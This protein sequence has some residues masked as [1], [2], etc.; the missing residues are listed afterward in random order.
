MTDTSED[1]TRGLPRPLRRLQQ[2]TQVL[3]STAVVGLG[4]LSACTIENVVPIVD[5]GVEPPP[6]E[7]GGAACFHDGRYYPEGARISGGECGEFCICREGLADCR[8]AD[9]AHPPGWRRDAGLSTLVDAA[10]PAPWDAGPPWSPSDAGPPPDGGPADGGAPGGCH[11]GPS[12]TSERW[13]VFDSNRGTG[14]RAIWTVAANGC[15]SVTRLMTGPGNAKEPAVSP[16]GKTVLFAS[17]RDSNAAWAIYALDLAS[18]AVRPVASDADQPTWSPDGKLIAYRRGASTLLANPDGTGERVLTTG[19]DNFNAHKNAAFSPDGQWIAFDRNNEIKQV[20]LDGTDERYI[21][22][23]WTTTLVEPTFSLDGTQIAY[24]GSCGTGPA[25][26]HTAPRGGLVGDPC[27]PA[28]TTDGVRSE[29]PSWG[30]DGVIAYER[31]GDIALVSV[32]EGQPHLL[33]TGREDDAN[34]TWAP[35]DFAPT[36]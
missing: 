33:T 13:I 19:L 16:D 32:V 34:P 21:V 35:A 15:G 2:R 14:T 7:D 3:L 10:W 8:I 23:N 30:P 36:P 31:D 18:G 27:G 24:T 29:H 17:D 11:T 20:R 25:S 28:I 6:S 1:A 12:A 5:G 9:C 26:L 4:T 22:P